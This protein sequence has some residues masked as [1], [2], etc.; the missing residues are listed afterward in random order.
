MLQVDPLRVLLA[1]LACYRLA[2]LVA[3]DDGPGDVLLKLRD[4]AGS[5][6]YGADGRPDTGWGRLLACPF[7]LGIW[8]AVPCALACIWPTTLGDAGLL[9]LGIAGLQTALQ[10]LSTTR[11]E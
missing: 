6:I 4:L 5:H 2:Q 8:F 7:C 11:D 9:I 10:S 1:A 3:L